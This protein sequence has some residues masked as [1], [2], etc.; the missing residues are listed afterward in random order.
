VRPAVAILREQG[1]NSQ[2][3]IA[4][5]FEFAG[6]ESHDVHMTDLLSGRRSLRDFKGLVA[7]GGFSYG[8]VLGAGEGW[9][10]SIL[11]HEA[12]REEL[13]RFFDR[14]ETFTLGVCNGC[15][16]LAALKSIVPGTELWPRFVRNRVEQFEGR[17]GMVEIQKSPSVLLTD[18]AG[19]F[20][21]IV[22]SHG[23]GRAEFTDDA[24]ARECRDSGL[25]AYRYANND[26]SV[27]KSYPANPNGSPF[28]IAALTNADGRVTITMPHPDRCYRYVTNSWRPDDAGEYSGWMRLFRN[29]RR[30]ID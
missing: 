24:V 7:C 27:A 15:Q 29:A 30:F 8:D 12:V 26:R 3:E 21:P 22:V 28:G 9:A 20:L 17:F 6:F 11:F 1:V 14:P 18:M 5:A 10:K 4:A 25:V 2:V 13:V 23:E 19:S 16:M